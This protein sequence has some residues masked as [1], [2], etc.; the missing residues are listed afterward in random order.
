MQKFKLYL[1][2]I[3]VTILL[4]C[5]VSCQP[6][7]ENPKK[8]VVKRKYEVRLSNSLGSD[9]YE[10]DSIIRISESRLQLKNNEEKYAWGFK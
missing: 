5:A 9:W 6:P 3:L 1:S 7:K 4:L 2:A 8:P 10:C